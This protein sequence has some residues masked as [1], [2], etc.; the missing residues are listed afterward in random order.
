MITRIMRR[1]SDASVWMAVNCARRVTQ[2]GGW[3]RT[4]THR[5]FTHIRPHGSCQL[6]VRGLDRYYV[7][8]TAARVSLACPLPLISASPPFGQHVHR[9]TRRLHALQVK[10]L[11]RRL[12]HIVA[13]GSISN[14]DTSTMPNAIHTSAVL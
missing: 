3:Y 11:T 2:T 14:K 4:L 1:S 7:A 13:T 10:S 9:T 6:L 8:V 5:R 12:A